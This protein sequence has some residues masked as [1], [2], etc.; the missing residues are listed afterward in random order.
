MAGIFSQTDPE[1]GE[2]GLWLHSMRL[3]P[4]A[5]QWTIE[6]EDDFDEAAILQERDDREYNDN[7]EIVCV[8][9]KD[10]IH[11]NF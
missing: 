7:L 9:M 5:S 11:H 3:E 2:L 6:T 8:T 4:G 1:T 10:S